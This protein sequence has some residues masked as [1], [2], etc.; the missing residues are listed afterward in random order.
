M[1]FGSVF[2]SQ[3]KTTFLLGFLLI[4]AFATQAQ[5]IAPL[6]E[7]QGAARLVTDSPSTSAAILGAPFSIDADVEHPQLLKGENG[8]G[9]LIIPQKTL[10][11]EALANAA[12][13]KPTPIAQLW[14]H[15]ATLLREG[16]ATPDERTRRANISVGDKTFDLQVYLLGVTK[17]AGTT[18]LVLFGRDSAPLI[19]I[20]LEK[21]AASQQ[22]PAEISG[23]KTGE[24][25]AT[26]TVSLLGQYKADVPLT[27]RAD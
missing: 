5:S 17:T 10:T 6:E 19:H 23:Q 26:L 21:I 25:R 24:D 1:A 4:P 13:G 9:A 15:K 8:A 16:Q 22:M 7:A 2:F 12:E 18:E 27:N 11:A 20:P 14:L 3:M